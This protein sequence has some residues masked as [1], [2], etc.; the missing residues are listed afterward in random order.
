MGPKAV[1]ILMGPDGKTVFALLKQN[2][3]L[4]RLAFSPVA[5]G[6]EELPAT[7]GQGIPA[8][9]DRELRLHFSKQ[10]SETL[11]FRL[12]GVN[13]IISSFLRGE[14]TF[15]QAEE[16]SLG[17]PDA[18]RSKITNQEK[19]REGLVFA[20]VA[21]RHRLTYTDPEFADQI[22]WQPIFDYA[23]S[24]VEEKTRPD[25]R[26]AIASEIRRVQGL[27][28]RSYHGEAYQD[29][30][31][32]RILEEIDRLLVYQSPF[33]AG[34]EEAQ[35]AFNRLQQSAAWEDLS[36]KGYVPLSPEQMTEFGVQADAAFIV[37]DS[38]IISSEGHQIYSDNRL[39][40]PEREIL[41]WV[42]SG[43]GAQEVVQYAR[44]S[45]ASA[46][47]LILIPPGERVSVESVQVLLREAGYSADLSDAPR[48]VLTDNAQLSL[49][50]LSGFQ[51][52][53]VQQGLPKV[54]ILNVGMKLTDDV[55]NTYTLLLMA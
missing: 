25:F 51:L 23:F 10:V 30:P 37:A 16:F 46:N 50:P 49:L 42:E 54:V 19:A 43:T 28:R 32:E 26:T 29:Q 48:V 20:W 17:R 40:H 8:S 34:L 31:A 21:L 9:E 22:W 11:G 5:A 53:I 15:E 52:L 55:G 6:L 3:T 24:S 45:G 1:K 33:A 18:G 12:A 36:G 14:L 7:P 47:D 44:Q 35:A 39:T 38:A 27:R 4:S 41:I 2:S 13:V